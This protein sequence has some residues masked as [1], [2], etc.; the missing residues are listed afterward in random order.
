MNTLTVG[1][2]TLELDKDG[3]LADLN[4]WSAEV[5]HALAAAEALEVGS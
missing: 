4:E 2:R 3:Y 5:A 1:A